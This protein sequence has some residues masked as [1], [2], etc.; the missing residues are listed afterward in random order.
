MKNNFRLEFV[1]TWRLTNYVLK[2]CPFDQIRTTPPSVV[3]V[4]P[5]AFVS[6]SR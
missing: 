6:L 1:D 5:V 2:N 3:T 4:D